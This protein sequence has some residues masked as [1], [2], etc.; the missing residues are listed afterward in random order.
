[1]NNIKVLDKNISEL[2]AA[3]EVIERPC[4]VVKELI[5][6]SIDSGANLITI[7]IKNG[8]ISYIR[9]TDNG[10]GMSKKDVP[11]AFLRHAT[12][13]IKEKNDLDNIIT[14]GF[15]G[16]ALASICAVAKIDII[17]KQKK[18]NY[19]THYAINGSKETIFEECG[20]PDGT[21][22]TVKD[23][24]YNIPARLKFLKKA[25]TEGNAISAII[26][27]T[28][29]SHP[30]I[31]F[32]FIRDNKT[33]LLS[34]G[35]GDLYS[36]IFA[37]LGK[38]IAKTMIPVDYTYNQIRVSGYTVKPIF[39]KAN[40]KHQ[41]FF[42]NNRYVKSLTCKVSLEEAY[43][44]LTMTSKF[45]ICVLNIETA[46][47][48]IDV[49]VHPTKIE[50]RF[51][52]EKLIFDSI[53]FAV[54]NALLKF[55]KPEKMNLENNHINKSDLINPFKAEKNFYQTSFDKK[56]IYDDCKIEDNIVSF[57]SDTV[58]YNDINKDKEN[59][60]VHLKQNESLSFSSNSYKQS[61]ATLEPIKPCVA[62][63]KETVANTYISEDFKYINTDSFVKK[64][65]EL[66]IED[67]KSIS[68][69]VSIKVIG[70]AF[71]TYVI[72]EINNELYFIDKHAAHERYIFEKIKSEDLDL[73]TQ[74][75]IQPIKIELTNQEVEILISNKLVLNKLGF[76]LEESNDTSIKITSIPSVL[77][78]YD[79]DNIICEI[80]SKLEYN[81]NLVSIDLLDDLY[82]SISCKAAIKGNIKSDNIELEKL[83]KLI[84]NNPDIKYC[85]HGRP[86]MF[87][88]TKKD[89]EKQ[90]KRIV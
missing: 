48:T 49:N 7:E 14:L 55:D 35:D 18:N 44:N 21:T 19:G 41:H 81:N 33:E 17:T 67:N 72:S 63:P 56:G 87:K 71:S 47:D 15:R 69:E 16:E 84:Y 25:V 23:I 45:P 24:F 12:S 38:D 77:S 52:D 57:N 74:M 4:S 70:E 86:I 68:E 20:C 75:L 62:A 8:G 54:K 31:S 90:F 36:N 40:R 32:R 13:K 82:H 64:E 30:D 3:G 34:P 42:I 11:V 37:I 60:K 61:V 53:Y 29:L 43:R 58:V 39:S 83:I 76:Q 46:P 66:N 73:E 88:I 50:V 51:T 5:E 1:M 2:I 80:A 6:N 78:E 10:C 28:A 27:K 79:L 65:P 22:I 9:I 59:E 89:L 85:P 26:T